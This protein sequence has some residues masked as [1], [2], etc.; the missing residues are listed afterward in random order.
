M[1][2]CSK[3]E[4]GSCLEEARSFG[5]PR[6]QAVDFFEVVFAFPVE[7]RTSIGEGLWCWLFGKPY[8]GYREIPV[9]RIL[10]LFL[11]AFSTKCQ[12]L[13]F[14]CRNDQRIEA[15]RYNEQ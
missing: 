1:N 5:Y 10:M 15:S 14:L 6:K 2:L 12:H 3:E 9:C 11:R 4:K 8:Q 7:A 13:W